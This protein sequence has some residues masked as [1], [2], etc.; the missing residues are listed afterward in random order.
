MAPNPYPCFVEEDLTVFQFIS[1][2]ATRQVPKQITF[3]EQGHGLYN[4]RLH[5]IDEDDHAGLTRSGNGDAR[6]VI[7]TVVVAV[8][9]FLNAFP[10]RWVMFYSGEP[11]QFD[12]VRMRLYRMGMAANLAY[13]Q[14]RVI[15]Y[16]VRPDNS[17]E[18]FDPTQVYVAILFK[19]RP[20]GPQEVAA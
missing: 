14:E 9:Q 11:Q 18:L 1:E 15:T 10:A 20:A 17:H 13:I 5:D 2:S 6:R 4:L 19:R 3:V 12:P 7:D 16:G 8:E